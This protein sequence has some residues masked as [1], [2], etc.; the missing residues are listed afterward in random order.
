MQTT[1]LSEAR[2][3]S[4]SAQNKKPE[5]LAAYRRLIDLDPVWKDP[6]SLAGL[7]GWTPRELRDLEKI[8]QN[9]VA[10]K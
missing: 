10:K 4:A 6:A 1:T 5:A 8:R 9:A 7:R 2:C 3:L